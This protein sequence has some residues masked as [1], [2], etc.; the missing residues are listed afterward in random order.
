MQYRGVFEESRAAQSAAGPK[1]DRLRLR[2][3]ELLLEVRRLP[4]IQDIRKA[5]K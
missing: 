2:E 1:L 3:A 5:T 4:R